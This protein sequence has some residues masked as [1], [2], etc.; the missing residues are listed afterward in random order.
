MNRNAWYY[1]RLP[2][3]ARSFGADIVHLSYPAPVNSAA[4][5]CPTVVTLHDLYPYEIPLNFGF[6]KFIF[7]R[8][9]LR[10]CLQNIGAIACVSDATCERL[11]QYAPPATWSKSLRI[12]NCV[13]PALLASPDVVVTEVRKHPFLLCVA[14]H[15]RNKNIPLLI[16]TFHH[17]LRLDQLGPRMKLL[18]V[19]ISGPETLR[20]HELVA[21]LGLA[22]RIYFREGLSN[23]QLQWC[24]AHCGALVAPSSTEG[25]GLP[26]AE[27][28]LAGCR[29]V[30]SDIPAFREVG[31]GHCLFIPLRGEVKQ[32]LANAIL[33]SL[34]APPLPPITLRQLSAPVLAEQYLELY[35]RLLSAAPLT[36]GVAFSSP[37]R[38][39]TERQSL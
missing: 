34:A 12:Y 1:R 19:G 16:R 22:D 3:L 28:L 31:A 30:C 35:R 26:I 21:E 20:I 7:N 4:Y 17:L 2:K 13:E 5:K 6:P 27:A 36:E 8:I 10:Q 37:I 23:A 9:I 25:F 11:R 39:T 29:V 15:R 24:Y 33:T 38:A 32:G 18:I 14:Q